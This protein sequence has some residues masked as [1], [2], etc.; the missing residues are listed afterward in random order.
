MA[1]KIWST[2]V[3]FFSSRPISLPAVK[4]IYASRRSE[5]VK[6]GEGVNAVEICEPFPEW[7]WPHTS[8]FDLV[9]IEGLDFGSGS[10]DLLHGRQ[11]MVFPFGQGWPAA[12]L[13][14]LVAGFNG[15]CPWMY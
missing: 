10:R 1:W 12:K 2:P 11:A 4:R 15:G 14:Y 7:A 6:L 13:R 3:E 5:A 8:P 9:K